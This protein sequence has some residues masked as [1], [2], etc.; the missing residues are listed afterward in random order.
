MAHKK[1]KAKER[2][3][4]STANPVE[5]G[6]INQNHNAKKVGMGPNTKR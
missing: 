4:A 5:D 1:S 6:Q 2:A 3:S